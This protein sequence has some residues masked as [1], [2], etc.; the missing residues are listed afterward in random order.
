M[1]EVE[2]AVCFSSNVC[3]FS[4]SFLLSLQFDKLTNDEFEGTL[5]WKR[6]QKLLMKEGEKLEREELQELLRHL[7]YEESGLS[8]LDLSAQDFIQHVLGFE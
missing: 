2:D 3:L 7:L 1:T 5:S 6:I 4:L 8:D